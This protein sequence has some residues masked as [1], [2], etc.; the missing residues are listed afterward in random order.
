L[1]FTLPPYPVITGEN[2]AKPKSPFR[3]PEQRLIINVLT[4]QF[5]FE[6]A[7]VVVFAVIGWSCSRDVVLDDLNF[8]PGENA[9]F[10]E[11]PTGQQMVGH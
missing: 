7:Y 1:I 6:T 3:F 5:L 4:A 10:A 2:R 11:N 8:L 9:D